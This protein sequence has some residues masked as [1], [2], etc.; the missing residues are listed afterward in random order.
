M[1]FARVPVRAALVSLAL[2][3][4][5]PQVELEGDASGSGG[6][7]TGGSSSESSAGVDDASTGP[8][9]P[10]VDCEA[11]PIDL[12]APAW[13]F[14]GMPERPDSPFDDFVV[15]AGG[16]VVGRDFNF[17]IVRWSPIG[18]EAW[19]I[20]ADDWEFWRAITA[21]P[22]GEAI[23]VGLRGDGP[24]GGRLELLRLSPDGERL[25]ERFYS[26][27]SPTGQL[28]LRAAFSANGDVVVEVFR[29]DGPTWW[30]QRYD[31]SFEPQW[32][33]ELDPERYH[34]GLGRDLAGEHVLAASFV[35][36]PGSETAWI[37]RLDDYDAAGVV[38]WSA[39]FELIAVDEPELEFAIG[40]RIYLLARDDLADASVL[41]AWDF[42]GNPIFSRSSAET[43]PI[44]IA[45]S[46]A[47]SPCGGA[48]V[49]GRAAADGLG[50]VA[51]LWHVDANGVESPPIV[52]ADQT[53]EG[54][55]YGA[56]S[57]LRASPLDELVVLGTMRGAEVSIEWLRGY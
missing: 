41:V 21:L 23:V 47:A 9:P 4:C 5:G 25:E 11:D 46:L 16:D 30:L 8:L 37:G 20:R 27:A 43:E 52:L 14:M 57:Q 28:P 45:T 24:E 42:E 19:R 10:P 15:L 36:D 51:A 26:D 50:T 56:V 55:S 2:V 54:W 6:V 13:A 29:P 18:H 40:D 35:L 53:P 3:A 48:Y 34:L 32:S 17:E 22:T 7:S 12:T 33:V 1:S 39:E 49:G 44:R 38:Q 31:A